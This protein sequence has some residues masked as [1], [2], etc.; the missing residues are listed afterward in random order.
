MAAKKAA[1]KEK[2]AEPAPLRVPPKHGTFG[3]ES[4][5]SG[6]VVVDADAPGPFA[7]PDET[8]ADPKAAKAQEQAQAEVED[9]DSERTVKVRAVKRGFIGN[10]IREEGDV[11]FLSLGESQKAPSWVVAE[12]TAPTTP[13]SHSAEAQEE[14][15]DSDGIGHTTESLKKDLVL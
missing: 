14:V 12:P 8:P 9:T 4:G 1:K 7:A 15:V 13:L 5:P 6:D 11:F 10:K 3:P 2:A